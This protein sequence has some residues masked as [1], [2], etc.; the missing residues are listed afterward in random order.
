VLLGDVAFC[1]DLSSLTALK[2]R[3]LDLT[4]VVTD[5]DGGAIFSFLPQAAAL[6]ADHRD[7]IRGGN[8]LRLFHL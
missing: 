2:A 8:A 6:P 5:N 7:A 3:D 1:H 4:I